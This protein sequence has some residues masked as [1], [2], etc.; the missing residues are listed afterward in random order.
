MSLLFFDEELV[1]Y[2]ESCCEDTFP[3]SQLEVSRLLPKCKL[4]EFRWVYVDVNLHIYKKFKQINFNLT[5]D[6][7]FKH[8]DLKFRNF[9]YKTSLI[10]STP[11]LLVLDNWSHNYFHFFLDVLP[12]FYYLSNKLGLKTLIVPQ[13]FPR[14]YLI[15]LELL[16]CELLVIKKFN[17]MFVRKLFSIDLIFQPSGVFSKQRLYPFVRYIKSLSSVKLKNENSEKFRFIY[18]SRA[19][20]QTRRLKNENEIISMLYQK[21]FLI[22]QLDNLSVVEQISYFKECK[23]LISTHGAGLTNMLFMEQGSH[24]L[25]IRQ[26]VEY[27]NNI[28]QR[29]ASELDL[30]YHPFLGKGFGDFQNDDLE[31]NSEALMKLLF[32]IKLT[33]S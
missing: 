32:D 7:E 24:V 14:K 11:C 20:A 28:Y 27:P 22:L 30:N 19:R 16:G 13:E 29:L 2:R 18:V 4:R 23:I 12:R 25:E 8:K 26:V 21:G 17:G 15:F 10:I 9:F 33:I 6:Y 1:Y 31:I 3:C 5:Q